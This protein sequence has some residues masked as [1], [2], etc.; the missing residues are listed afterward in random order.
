MSGL[1]PHR[2][3]PPYAFVPGKNPHPL[4]DPAGHCYGQSPAECAALSEE[5]WQTNDEYLWGIEL[6]NHGYYWE[7]HESWEGVWNA[8][9]RQ[10]MAADFLKGLIKLAA[11]GVKVREGRP[12]GVAQHGRRA[13]E[14]FLS[15]QAR[16]TAPSLF[17]LA[18]ADLLSLAR[19]LATSADAITQAAEPLVRMQL[20][21]AHGARR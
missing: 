11:A 14:L 16:A 8:C 13:E 4:R 21:L 3:F 19:W 5:N 1:Q 18:L 12:R 15:V 7:A 17:G 2:A 20:S 9:G 10:G 6:F